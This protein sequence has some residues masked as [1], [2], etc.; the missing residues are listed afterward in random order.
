MSTPSS[1]QKP[2]VS[3]LKRSAAMPFEPAKAAVN[4]AAQIMGDSASSEA[5]RILQAHTE[6]IKRADTLAFLRDAL[7]AFKA[8]NWEKGGEMALKALHVDEKCGDAWHYLA[9][10]REKL[11]DLATALTCYESAHKLMPDNAAII[12]DLGRLAYRLDLND[13]AEKFFLRFIEMSPGHVEAVNNLASVWRE[14][15]RLDDAVELLRGAIQLTPDSAQL[16]NALGTVV[17]ARG[18][19]TN[20]VIFYTEALRHDPR[21][22]HAHYNLGNAQCN[23]GQFDEGRDHL[24]TALPIFADAINIHTCKLSIAFSYLA[25]GDLVPGWDWYKARDKDGTDENMQY[26]ID[27]PQ[28]QPGDSL[29]GKRLF[30]S[31]EQGLGDEIM[32]AGILPDL[33]DEVGPEGHVTIGVEPRLVSLFAR[34]FPQCTVT[35]HHTTRYRTRPVRLFPDMED[36]SQVDAWATM[37]QFLP[38]YRTQVSDF[39]QPAF[40]KADPERVAYWKAQLAELNDQPKVGLLWKSLIKHSRRD[41]YY[42]PFSQWQEVLSVPGVQ[43]INLQYGDTTEEMEQ[44][45]ALGL[46]IWTPPDIDLKQDLDDLAALTAALDCVL[47]PANAT[48]NIAGAVGTEIWIVSQAH[49]WNSLGTDRFPWYPKSRVF[50]SPSMTDWTEVMGAVKAAVE[51]R[52]APGLFDNRVA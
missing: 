11:G 33:L 4:P 25:A 13:L 10:A 37:G 43:F 5:L 32:F 12:N 41:R 42:S 18:D 36:W 23:L 27:R 3:D 21:H 50:F 6:T 51:D 30:L 29:A 34:S 20:S 45:A 52:F 7:L 8:G 14:G 15:N 35:R 47:G 46:D 48:S 39:D 31:A 24:M 2:P 28:W 22:V 26:L 1:F 17:N 44:A 40:L 38:R 49:A 19:L 9:V 16:W